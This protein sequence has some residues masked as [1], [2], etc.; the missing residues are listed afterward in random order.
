[1]IEVNPTLWALLWESALLLL[2]LLGWGVMAQLK[3]R[4]RQQLELE[5]LLQPLQSTSAAS[6][7]RAFFASV[8]QMQGDELE[9]ALSQLDRSKQACYFSLFKVYQQCNEE[10][11]MDYRQNLE[12]LLACFY[13]VELPIST[14]V[15]QVVTSMD[16]GV[17]EVGTL[18]ALEIENDGLK[19]ENRELKAM[20]SDLNQEIPVSKEEPLKKVKEVDEGM[21]LQMSQPLA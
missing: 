9:E 4:K 10:S 11:V 8:A 3:Q 15:E 2:L 6:P 17:R 19:V 7:Y 13:R 14:T 1:M 20:L 12:Q 18:E 5:A 21:A 16:I